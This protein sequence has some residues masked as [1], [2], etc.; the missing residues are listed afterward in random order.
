[1]SKKIKITIISIASIF[2]IIIILVLN[3]FYIVPA[4]Y[5]GVILTWGAVSG[6]AEQGLHL[7]IPIAQHIVNMETR[8]VKMEVQAA[9]YSK[10][11][12]TVESLIALNYH[13]DES[14]VSILYREIGKEFENRIISPAVQESVK[15]TTA[16]FTAQELIEEREQVRDEIKSS[17]V[18]KLTD[19]GILVDAFSIV[20]F[21]FSD[22]YEQAV[23]AKQVAQQ[24]AL[25]AE[26]DLKRIETEAKQRVAQ[27]EAEAKAI[28]LQ[29][30]AAN[31]EKYVS[32]KALEVQLE[33]IK[34]WD[35]KL[36]ITFVP[37]ST[38]PFLN[39]T[40]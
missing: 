24:Q 39:L 33:A 21:D 2:G 6:S 27:A 37:N 9:A 35:G 19:R 26:N 20:N 30:Q 16:K 29:S 11:I 3:P 12:Q 32:L 22:S 1:M 17:L 8:T 40:K 7:R 15:A 18:G 14:R 23:E 10:D 28:Q 38:L 25:K 5:R 34:K 4:G 13:L 31:N 36:P